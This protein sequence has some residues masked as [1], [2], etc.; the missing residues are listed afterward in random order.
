MNDDKFSNIVVIKR[1]GKKVPFNGMKIAVAIKKGFDSVENEY[2]EDDANTV[3]NNV[4]A[5]IASE[6]L[7][8]IKIEQIQDYI[9]E[10]LE[11]SGYDDVY[12]SFSTYRE[13]RNQSRELFLDEKRKH[14]F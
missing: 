14:K 12:K 2:N 3:Y 1:S 8:K 6:N 7:D 9:E 10:E 4:I 11:K 13:K 5:R